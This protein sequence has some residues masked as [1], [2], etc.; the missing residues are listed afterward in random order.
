MKATATK[1]MNALDAWL[2]RVNAET[3]WN[4]SIKGSRNTLTGYLINGHLAIVLRY[5]NSGHDGWELLIPASRENSVASTLDAAA[6]AF[7]VDGCRG[8]V[9]EAPCEPTTR[10][11]L[12]CRGTGLAS[13][14]GF[15]DDTED[16]DSCRGTGEVPND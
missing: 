8:L 13:G 2:E 6:M 16:C 15:S 3:T 7:Q 12:D 4:A 9:E 14:D 1:R 5:E 10:K 11:C